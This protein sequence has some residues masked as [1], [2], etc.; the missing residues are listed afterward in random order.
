M[1]IGDISNKDVRLI[2]IGR[3]GSMVSKSRP[4]DDA[5]VAMI[6]SSRSI[7]R[8]V[9]QDLGPITIPGIK[10]SVPGLSW[11]KEY[12]GAIGRAIYQRGVDVEI[13]LSNPRSTPGGLEGKGTKVSFETF[14]GH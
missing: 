11:P 8:L 5:I 3:Q 7:I 4:S 6:D 10:K 2:S 13:V 14:A 1:Q 12:L 9:I